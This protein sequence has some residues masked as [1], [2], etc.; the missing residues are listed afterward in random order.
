[1]RAGA[2]VNGGGRHGV[3]TALHHVCSRARNLPIVEQLLNA[4]ADVHATDS[5]QRVEARIARYRSLRVAERQ[6]TTAGR[7]RV[8]QRSSHPPAVRGHRLGTGAGD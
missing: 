7:M 4:G 2:P 5:V 3:D 8:L 1:M 6:N